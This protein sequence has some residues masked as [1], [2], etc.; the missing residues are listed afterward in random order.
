M[1]QFF[2]FFL[3]FIL[4]TGCHKDEMSKEKESGEISVNSETLGDTSMVEKD[5]SY[6]KPVNNKKVV[7]E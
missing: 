1:K 5:W 6:R 4:L 2:I 3:T 7:F